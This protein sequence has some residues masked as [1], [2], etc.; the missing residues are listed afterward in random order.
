MFKAIFSIFLWIVSGTLVHAQMSG[1]DAIRAIKEYL[2]DQELMVYAEGKRYGLI[3]SVRLDCNQITINYNSKH[4]AGGGTLKAPW[5]RIMFDLDDDDLAGFSCEASKC[6][7][8]NRNSSSGTYN[9]RVANITFS[10][11]PVRIGSRILKPLKAL[12]RACGKTIND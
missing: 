4:T 11:D 12:D 5:R 8:Y 6:F 10:F 2:F 1:D 3:T 9:Y 7:E